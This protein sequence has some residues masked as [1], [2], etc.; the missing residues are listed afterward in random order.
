MTGKPKD[1]Q[2]NEYRLVLIDAQSMQILTI[3]SRTDLLLP[4]ETIPAYTRVAK[5]LTESIKQKYGFDTMQLALIQGTEGQ[6]HC[7][8]HEIMNLRESAS[9]SVQFTELHEIAAS[10]FAGDERDTVLKI[11]KGEA[12]ELGRFARLGWINELLAN[13]GGYLGRS[14]M[15]TIR[16]LNQGVNFCLLSL[17]DLTGRKVWFKAVGKPNTREYALTAELTRRFPAYLPRILKTIPEWN[18]WVMEDV[19]GV[20]LNESD[21]IDQYEQALDALAL[22][23]KEMIAD[24]ASL[25]ALGAKDWTCRRIASLSESFFVE[26]L[27]AMEAQ[28]STKS[29]PLGSDELHQLKDNIELALQEFSDA[30]IPE[31]LVHGDIGHGN[32]IATPNGPVFLDWA[33]AYVGHPFLSAEH[34]LADLVRS[35]PSFSRSQ[36]VLRSHYAAH[37]NTLARPSDLERVAV[38]AP[39]IAAFTYGIIAWDANRSR[40]DSTIGWPLLRSL[41]RR[42]KRELDQV[43]E[44]NA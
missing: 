37:W 41:V 3:A 44:V 36:A 24:V 40:S 38:F 21:S 30:R 34:L 22:M 26:A 43:S 42:T 4:R 23:Q 14:S 32:I 10:E 27:R 28:V 33:E 25:S 20:P 8:V 2:C 7:S 1:P 35:S 13:M 19:G 16:Q 31:T 18:G 11:M 29:R 6:S 12:N 39:A 15:P 17:T 5:A 9:Q